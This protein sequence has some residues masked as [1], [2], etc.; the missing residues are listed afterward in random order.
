[1]S[2]TLLVRRDTEA[3]ALASPM[4][5]EQG[6]LFYCTDKRELFVGDGESKY[7]DLKPIGCIA[8]APNGQLFAVDVDNEGRS[9]AK[10]LRSLAGTHPR[11]DFRLFGDKDGKRLSEDDEENL[12]RWFEHIAQIADNRKTA[13]GVS[14]SE[15]AALD[16]IRAIAKDSVYYIKHAL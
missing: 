15:Q 10:P 3:R 4:T 2:V 8:K 1:M 12:V 14:M 16:E 5:L 11:Q 9:K 7:K 13:N 6:E